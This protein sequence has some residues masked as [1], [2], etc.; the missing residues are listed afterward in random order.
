MLNMI[1]TL[2]IKMYRKMTEC[3]YS[4]DEQLKKIYMEDITVLL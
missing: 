2:R 4:A 1:K 3:S